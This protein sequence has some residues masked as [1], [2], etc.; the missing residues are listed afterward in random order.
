MWK[1]TSVVVTFTYTAV[2]NG[3][4]N[5]NKVTIT[6][7]DKDLVGNSRKSDTWWC[8]KALKKFGDVSA[9]DFKVERIKSYRR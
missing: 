3:A 6:F 7:T 1:L 8:E 2:E 5:V 9:E 4:L